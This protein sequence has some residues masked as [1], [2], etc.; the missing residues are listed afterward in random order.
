V[1][2]GYAACT[3][4]LKAVALRLESK[5]A[6]TGTERDLLRQSLCFDGSIIGAACLRSYPD[7]STVML[8]SISRSVFARFIDLLA[9]STGGTAEVIACMTQKWPLVS[10]FPSASDCSAHPT[11]APVDSASLANGII[12]I[13]SL[14]RTS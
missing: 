9:S 11:T 12:G 2:S 8:S 14:G 1:A 6:I 7:R 10:H 4:V 13:G 5:T 3:A